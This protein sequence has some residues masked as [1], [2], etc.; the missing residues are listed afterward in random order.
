MLQVIA[1]EVL[2]LSILKFDSSANQLSATFVGVRD[3]E[4]FSKRW[5]EH[6]CRAE[7]HSEDSKLAISSCVHIDL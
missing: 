4:N 6:R 7:S 2:V 3:G 1:D 5:F